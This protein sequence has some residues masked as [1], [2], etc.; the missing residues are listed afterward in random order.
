MQWYACHQ[1]YVCV[2]GCCG[3]VTS[4][5]AVFGKHQS[6][7]VSDGYVNTFWPSKDSNLL[8]PRVLL[9]VWSLASPRPPCHSSL[10]RCLGQHETTSHLICAA[11]AL[12]CDS[13]CSTV[14]KWQYYEWS[15]RTSKNMFFCRKHLSDEAGAISHASTGGAHL[16]EGPKVPLSCGALHPSLGMQ[17][18]V[19]SPAGQAVHWRAV[20]SISM[21][22]WEA[23]ASKAS[24]LKPS[25]FVNARKILGGVW[26]L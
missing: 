11:V 23:A 3:L 14:K 7:W 17:E 10:Q 5:S 20:Q 9:V 2:F 22:Q 19:R 18:D 21:F 12:P 16:A 6:T 13:V 1:C 25:N 4:Q 26:S 24:L 8:C 15:H